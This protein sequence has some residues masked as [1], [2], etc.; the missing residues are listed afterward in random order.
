MNDIRET[1]YNQNDNTSG[2][3]NCEI[4]ELYSIFEQRTINQ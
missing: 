2:F 3:Y 4:K 1:Y